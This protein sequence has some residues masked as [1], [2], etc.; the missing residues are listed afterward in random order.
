[1]ELFSLV[2]ILAICVGG[3]V[4]GYLVLEPLVT[5]LR[6]PDRPARRTQFRTSDLLWL[7]MLFH[8]P[9]V[10]VAAARHWHPPEAVG[11]FG[12]LLLAA[13]FYLW[14]RGIMALSKLG[15]QQ[16]LR[17]GIFLALALPLAVLGSLLS[18]VAICATLAFL[19]DGADGLLAAGWLGSVLGLSL[20]GWGGRCLTR[21]ILA[22]SAAPTLQ[23]PQAALC[24]E[25]V[26]ERA[27]G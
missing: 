17:R 3:G 22:G 7:A 8:M 12:F 16:P 1:M 26:E 9:L 10:Y 4:F 2:L 21:W 15:I 24:P 5:A 19:F 27:P 13:V 18:M 23:P 6:D 11:I 25:P 14:F 20:A